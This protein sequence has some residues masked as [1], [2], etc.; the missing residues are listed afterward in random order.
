LRTSHICTRSSPLGDG[1][2]EVEG[3]GLDEGDPVRDGDRPGFEV[4]LVQ[5]A[6]IVRI[7]TKGR[8]RRTRPWTLRTP[9][10]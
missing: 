7:R 3:D 1:C 5:L 8:T 9:G 10:A 4:V 2:G 6:E